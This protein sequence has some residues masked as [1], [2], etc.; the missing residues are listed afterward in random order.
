M[1]DRISA[2]WLTAARDVGPAG[3]HSLANAVEPTPFARRL[4]RSSAD[5]GTPSSSERADSSRSRA[6]ALSVTNSPTDNGAT[7]RRCIDCATRLPS[8]ACARTR[9]AA[10]IAPASSHAL[11]ISSS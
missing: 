7:C 10:R 6:G 9:L 4:L 5:N 2:G 3:R 8:S 11:A 1:T